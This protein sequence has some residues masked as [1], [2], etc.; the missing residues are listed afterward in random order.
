MARPTKHCG[1]WRIRR[2]D[3]HRGRHSET[4]DTFDE[5]AFAQQKR[6]LEVK[7]IRRG[8]RGSILS[9]KTVG[10]VCNYWLKQR[11]PQKRSPKDDTSIIKTHIRRCWERCG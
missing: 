2:A 5:A 1:K 4:F 10:D 3:E 8:L 9:N 11:V 7:E 6:E